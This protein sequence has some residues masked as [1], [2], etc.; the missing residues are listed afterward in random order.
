MLIFSWDGENKQEFQL[1][2]HMAQAFEYSQR[3]DLH[4]SR[5]MHI[6]ERRL[7][8]CSLRGV[9]YFLIIYGMTVVSNHLNNIY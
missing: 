6:K 1:Y 9:F 2:M 3:G 8:I 4:K 5:N 7:G